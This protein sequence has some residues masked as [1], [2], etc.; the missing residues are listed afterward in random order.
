MG[1][2]PLVPRIVYWSN[3]LLVLAVWPMLLVKWLI[4][5]GSAGAGELEVALQRERRAAVL[6]SLGFGAR[7]TARSK[8]W[9]GDGADI[10]IPLHA[11]DCRP[12]AVLAHARDWQGWTRAQASAQEA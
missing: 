11:L 10:A 5:T 2:P 1:N 6:R 9:D 8:R 3:V 4:V 7:W 12:T